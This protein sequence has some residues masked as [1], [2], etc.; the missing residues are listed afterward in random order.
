LRS[1]NNISAENL[2]TRYVNNYGLNRDSISIDMILKHWELEKAL[3]K[4]LLASTPSNRKTVFYEAYNT[5]YNE[6]PWLVKTGTAS[7]GNSTKV[8]TTRWLSLLN[9]VK[10]KHIYEIGSGNGQLITFL[11]DQGGICTG[12]EISE[13]RPNKHPHPNLEWHETDGVNLIK[14]ESEASY[15]FV[16][17]DQLIEHLHPDDIG[18]H[19]KNACQLLK[20]GGKYIFYTPHYYKGPGDVSLVFGT[21][22]AEGMH[23]KE[24]KFH[25]IFKLLKAAGFT[26]IYIPVN[27]KT[28]T[29][30]LSAIG[31]K[32]FLLL[33]KSLSVFKNIRLRKRIYHRLIKPFH[34]SDELVIIAQK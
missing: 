10:G 2:V 11:A 23:L 14:Y 30:M 5:L 6:L 9:D 22:E 27:L 34:I 7:D 13:N 12:T 21:L 31:I 24:Y 8:Y 19:F 1:Y 18:I 26:K 20:S 17:S 32:G 15:D 3:T 28:N 25:E 16:I 33:E 29:K 4:Q